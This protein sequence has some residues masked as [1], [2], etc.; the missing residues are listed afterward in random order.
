MIV[1]CRQF[2]AARA[3]SLLP[4]KTLSFA[5]TSNVSHPVK[6][7]HSSFD[8]ASIMEDKAGIFASTDISPDQKSF[9][10]LR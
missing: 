10:L 6:F 4:L 9:K 3:T 1:V 8:I 7:N 5:T 2:I